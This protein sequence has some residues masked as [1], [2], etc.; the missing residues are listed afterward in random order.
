MTTPELIAAV[1]EYNRLLEAYEALLQNSDD[2]GVGSSAEYELEEF[3]RQWPAID[4]YDSQGN[5]IGTVR[6]ENGW[7]P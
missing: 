7:T 6:N 4:D 5:Y 1:A 3:L 2:M